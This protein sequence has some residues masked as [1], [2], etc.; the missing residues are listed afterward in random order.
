MI[1]PQKLCEMILCRLSS[2]VGLL[3]CETEKENPAS[4]G[5][6]DGRSRHMP[7]VSVDLKSFLLHQSQHFILFMSCKNQ[8]PGSFKTND[9]PGLP[10]RGKENNQ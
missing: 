10:F 7:H 9:N 4:L 5:Q 6:S 3:G 2:Y 8:M 1:L